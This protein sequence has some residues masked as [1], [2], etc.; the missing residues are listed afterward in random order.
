MVDISPFRA[1]RPSYGKKYSEVSSF[2]CPP[3][4]VISPSDRLELLK[5]SS[6]NVVQLEL[7]E[8][9][10]DEKYHHAT[11]LLQQWKNQEVLQHDRKPSF[12]IL[13]TTYKINDP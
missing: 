4:D 10:G 1:L 12:Y 2:I 3:Y 11:V 9:E 6:T 13:E 8:G 7:P 5:K